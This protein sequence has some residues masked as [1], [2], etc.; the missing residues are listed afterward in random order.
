MPEGESQVGLVDI[1]NGNSN[2]RK[3]TCTHVR[4][5]GTG[6]VTCLAKTPLCLGQGCAELSVQIQ[7]HVLS[8]QLMRGSGHRLPAVGHPGS[9]SRG[10]AMTPA[11]SPI[12]PEPGNFSP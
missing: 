9:P 12:L 2:L 6:W 8:F 7:T 4:K 1:F 3:K 5:E 11:A 10:R